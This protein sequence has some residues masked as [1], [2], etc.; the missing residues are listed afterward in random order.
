MGPWGTSA[1]I[2]TDRLITSGGNP[3]GADGDRD[4]VAVAAQLN[5]WLAKWDLNVLPSV[6]LAWTRDQVSRRARFT[7]A[8]VQEPAT[9]YLLP[10]YRLGIIQRPW[11]SLTLRANAGRY[12]RLPTLF[13]R[14]GDPPFLLPNPDIKPERGVNADVG[15]TFKKRLLGVRVQLDVTGFLARPSDLIQFIQVRQNASKSANVARARLL[16]VESAA[17]IQWRRWVRLTPR[18]TFMHTENRAE[19]PASAGRM[20]ANRVPWRGG[21]RLDVLAQCRWGICVEAHGEW[22]ARR[23]G[24]FDEVELLPL[25]D[26]DLWNAGGAIRR[27]PATGLSLVVTGFNLGNTQALDILN[28]PLPGRMV[29]FELGWIWSG[30]SAGRS[31]G[32][33]RPTTRI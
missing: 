32:P 26:R 24:Y 12:V 19:T 20:L 28:F 29:M 7:R 6:R 8:P 21:G 30:R 33:K 4:A 11:K 27:H 25:E 14:Y 13:E 23:G 9:R 10:V 1:P 17:Y 22:T 2:A 5:L 15:L 18:L 3:G 16:G 31:R